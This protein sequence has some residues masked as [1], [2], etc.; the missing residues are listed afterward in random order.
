MSAEEWCNNNGGCQTVAAHLSAIII[1]HSMWAWDHTY[2]LL[3]NGHEKVMKFP[4]QKP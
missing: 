1:V 3:D 2:S 4:Y